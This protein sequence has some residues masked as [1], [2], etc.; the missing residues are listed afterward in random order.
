M[1]T[2]AKEKN[3]Q[4]PRP[5]CSTV[6][7]QLKRRL[8][9]LF[10]LFQGRNFSTEKQRRTKRERRK[11]REAITLFKWNS[12][13]EN[14]ERTRGEG[15]SVESNKINATPIV[16]WNDEIIRRILLLYDVLLS[17]S[18]LWGFSCRIFTR[19]GIGSSLTTESTLRRWER[20][21]KR[22]QNAE[23]NVWEREREKKKR[24]KVRKDK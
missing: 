12:I 24:T 22:N 23:Q 2:R 15:E 10:W 17:R 6:Q 9:T 21:K 1:E 13:H 4:K 5:L 16:Q 20:I 11:E 18:P 19:H 14:S 8:F 7:N 3:D